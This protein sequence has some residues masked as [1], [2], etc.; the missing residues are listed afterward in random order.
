MPS[1]SGIVPP[2]RRIVHSEIDFSLRTIV[3]SIPRRHLTGRPAAAGRVLRV[4]VTLRQ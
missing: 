4:K 3:S 2:D 1:A